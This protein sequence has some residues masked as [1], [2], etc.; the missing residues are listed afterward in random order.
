MSKLMVIGILLIEF[1]AFI[2][3]R[4]STIIID[5]TLSTL[6]YNIEIQ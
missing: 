6:G 2:P 5:Y 3:T 4:R 1:K